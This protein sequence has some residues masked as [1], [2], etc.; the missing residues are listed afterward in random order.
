MA[1][2]TTQQRLAATIFAAALGYFVD[3]FDLQLFSVLRVTSLKDLGLSADSLTSTGALL[4]NSQMIG[5]L[6]GGLVWG[7]LGDT[8]GR[9]AVL[10]GTILL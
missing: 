2:L 4:L 1:R 3:L 9:V 6:L 10:V 5:M 8:R 7:T